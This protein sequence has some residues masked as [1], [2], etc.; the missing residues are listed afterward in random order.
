MDSAESPG[1]SGRVFVKG[2]LSTQTSLRPPGFDRHGYYHEFFL[3]G[4]AFLSTNIKRMKIKGKGARKRSAPESEPDFY[5]MPF[6]PLGSDDVAKDVVSCRSALSRSAL[7]TPCTPSLMPASWMSHLPAASIDPQV[8]SPRYTYPSNLS[9]LL[10]LKQGTEARHFDLPTRDSNRSIWTPSLVPAPWMPQRLPRAAID[11]QLDPSRY[12]NPPSHHG[13]LL[14]VTPRPEAGSAD[15]ATHSSDQ[16]NMS[17]LLAMKHDIG[18]RRITQQHLYLYHGA[19]YEEYSQRRELPVLQVD[20]TAVL[21][22]LRSP[23]H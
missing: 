9:W 23:H 4:K 15:R 8:A 22:A 11:A 6:L 12:S 13:P 1:V 16:S 14:Q 10:Q 21:M 20:D 7:Q 5:V 17:L 19:F 2:G 3:R 18:H